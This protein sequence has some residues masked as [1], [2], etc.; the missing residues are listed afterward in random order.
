MKLILQL[1]ARRQFR[2]LQINFSFADLVAGG[3]IDW[4]Y[5]NLC[6]KH[7]YAIE[8]RDKGD[9]GFL[10]PSKYIIPTAE[11]YYA[12]F[13]VVAK[14]VA[15]TTRNLTRSGCPRVINKIDA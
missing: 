2:L 14:H 13:K 6:V 7:S 10:L 11:E 3:S 5:L 8:L 12:G 1:C 15:M 9:Y 4:V